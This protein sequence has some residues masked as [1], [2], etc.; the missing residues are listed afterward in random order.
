M[1]ASPELL[2]IYGAMPADPAKQDAWTK[3]IDKNFPGIKLDWD[4]VKAAIAYP[5]IP[6]NQSYV[7]NYGE[8]KAAFQA[9]QNKV[10]TTAGLNMDTELA[11][12]K[13]TLQGIFD[14]PAN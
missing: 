6:N 10:R 1:V 12:L 2:T 9:F 14:K 7:P 3:S 5:D 13:T 11:N 4:V 8:A